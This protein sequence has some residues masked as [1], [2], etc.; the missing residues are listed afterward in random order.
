MTDDQGWDTATLEAM[1]HLTRILA[2]NPSITY[3][4]SF[5]PNS[6]CCPSRAS[7]LTGDYSHTTGVFGNKGSWGGFGAFTPA[8][9]GHSTSSVNDTT[10]IATGMH[11]AGYRTALIG[12]YLNGY[13]G[14]KHWNYVPPGWDRWFA[15]ATGVY[16]DYYAATNGHQSALFGSDP[17]DY[18]TRVL[19]HRAN[20]FITIPSTQ[21]FFLYYATTAPHSPS[22]PDPL[23][24]GRF[25]PSGYIHSP[26]FGVVEDGAPDYIQALSWDAEATAKADGFYAKQLDAIY[27]VDRSIGKLWSALPDTTVVLFM[28]DN[29]LM[30]GSH[31]WRPK[32]VPYN[33]AIRIPIRI[34]GKNLATPLSTTGH[35]GR[36]VL[37]VDVLPTLE[38]LAGFTSGHTIE[39][40]DMLTSDRGRFVLEHWSGESGLVPTYCGVRSRHWMYVR[41]NAQEEPVSEGLYDEANDPYEMNNLAVTDPTNPKLDVM[42]DGAA[43]LCRESGGLYPPD[44][45]F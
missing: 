10:T 31:R 34:V 13:P 8:P 27:G 36:I 32:E 35:D 22:T 25:A 44:W 11:D 6:M 24:V 26:N 5:V 33:E 39:G 12:K 18:I 15:V 37:N 7:T 3:A 14:G 28:S 42:R 40:L 41:Y 16:Y 9:E 4:N 45:P 19:Q 43:A 20:A 30:T 23:D 21:P 1:P 2:N 17:K 29:G 38:R